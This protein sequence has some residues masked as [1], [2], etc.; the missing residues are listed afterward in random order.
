ML[1]KIDVHNLKLIKLDLKD[2]EYNDLDFAR[3]PNFKFVFSTY[4]YNKDVY[5]KNYFFKYH[6]ATGKKFY[7]SKEVICILYDKDEKY[8]NIVLEERRESKCKFAQR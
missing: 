5:K 1:N 3:N 8:V 6:L 4:N 2:K 7:G